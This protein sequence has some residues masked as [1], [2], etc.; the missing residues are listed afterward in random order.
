MGE[1]L[2]VGE[3]IHIAVRRRFEGD[4]RRHFAG[5]VE[6]VA[7]SVVRL[8]GCAFVWSNRKGEF[9]RRPESRVRIIDV[10]DGAYIVNV[11]PG[12][13]RV[14]GLCYRISDDNRLI[15]TDGAGFTLDVHE[16]GSNR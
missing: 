16:F 8:V 11:L 13:V 5:Q 7:G 4:L 1:V 6:A 3:K 14:A 10:A 15:L 9:E 2:R 12:E